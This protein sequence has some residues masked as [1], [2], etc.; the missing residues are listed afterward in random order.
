MK[1]VDVRLIS[2]EVTNCNARESSIDIR[3]MLNDG[4]DKALPRS[5]NFK[6]TDPQAE[7]QA[8]FNEMREKIKSA[9]KSSGGDSFLDNVVNIRFKQDEEAIVERLSKYLTTLRDMFRTTRFNQVSYW[10]LER[11]VMSHKASFEEAKRAA[12]PVKKV[13]DDD[14][15]EDDNDV[16]PPDELGITM[17][18]RPSK[19]VRIR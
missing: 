12:A 4:K 18:D 19:P 8:I 5:I 1:N 17:M 14:D 13:E 16:P 9:N 11:K 2:A 10:D 7:A 3:I 6:K 15:F